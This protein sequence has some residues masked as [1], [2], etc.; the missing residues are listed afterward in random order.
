MHSAE[1]DMG[2]AS[3]LFLLIP[4]Y[5]K[6]MAPPVLRG[7]V[8]RHLRNA[9]GRS[10]VLGMVGGSIWKF[11]YADPKRRKYEEFYKNYDAEKAA[12][13]MEADME[14]LD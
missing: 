10:L 9:I 13:E 3:D 12:K 2:F 5:P 7:F 4:F 6:V 8:Q 14:P 11:G 1:L